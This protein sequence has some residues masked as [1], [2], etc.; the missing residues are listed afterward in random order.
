MSGHPLEDIDRLILGTLG[1]GAAVKTRQHLAACTPCQK[2]FDDGVLMLRAARGGLEQPGLGELDRIVARATAITEGNVAYQPLSRRVWG[3]ALF[4]AA[5]GALL[6]LLWPTP[7]VGKV[8]TA[9]AELTIDG[10]PAAVDQPVPRGAKVI[11]AKGDS[12]LLLDGQRGVLLREGAIARVE[13]AGDRVSLE[14]GRA[15]FSVKPNAGRF[16]VL[17]GKTEV[18]VK[19]TVFVVDRKTNEETLVAVHRGE[20]EVRDGQKAVAVKGGQE[21]TVKAQVASPAVEV[22]PGSLA[23]DRGDGLL[24]MIL[25]ALRKVLTAIDEAVGG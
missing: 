19:G 24:D 2:R 20:V 14:Q 7:T 13:G 1:E 23:E 11:A 9:G 18:E 10:Q 16:L 21:T 6:V 15:R 4:A 22:R 25:R 5:A 12:A 3:V 17:A 8:L